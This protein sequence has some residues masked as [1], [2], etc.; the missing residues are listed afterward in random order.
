MA[1]R[2]IKSTCSLFYT[3]ILQLASIRRHGGSFC[4]EYDWV[5]LFDKSIVTCHSFSLRWYCTNLMIRDS[6]SGEYTVK[7]V[8]MIIINMYCEEVPI[9]GKAL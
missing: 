3:Q 7:Y 8:A 4:H 5:V 1:G 9:K 2:L 6:L